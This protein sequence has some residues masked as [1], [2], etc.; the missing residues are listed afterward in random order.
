MNAPATRI[1]ISFGNLPTFHDGLGEYSLQFGRAIAA[2]A[3]ALRESDGFEFHFHLPERLHGRF[4]D[5]VKYLGT[6]D[7]QRVI[8][9][10]GV[11]FALWHSLHQHNRYRAPLFTGCSIQTV[12]DLNFLYF[13]ESRKIRKYVARNARLLARSSAVVAISEYVR[14][15]IVNHVRCKSPV[16]VIYN[17]VRDLSQSRQEPVRPLLD[18]KFFFHISRMAPTKNIPAILELARAWPQ[19]RFVLA[20]P[21]SDETVRVGMDI[22]SRGLENVTLLQDI[23]DAQKAWLFAHCEGF[24]F[25]SLTEGFGLPPIEAMQFGK[26]VFLST[27]TCLPEI[28]GD[29]AYY[30]PDFA[31]LAM[32]S[33]VESALADWN[34]ARGARTRARAAAFTWPR[35]VDQHLELYR[36]L[37]AG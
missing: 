16:H 26:P 30:W 24:L 17:G 21:Q 18:Q 27:R 3:P 23:N 4:G 2:R 12:H 9:L 14:N 25:P 33:V 7:V 10:P 19:K 35:C 6:S 32:R 8:H 15:D 20:G 1:G 5:N 28:G 31:P 36:K 22:D 11:R 29:A 37:L 34:E 13:K